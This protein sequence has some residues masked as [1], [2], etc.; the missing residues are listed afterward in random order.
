MLTDLADVLRAGGLQVSEVPGWQTRGRPGGML[1]VKTIIC[2]HTGGLNDLGT[3]IGG[4]SDL[5]GPLAQLWLD[6]AGV[7][8]VVAA[9]KCNHAG[10]SRATEYTNSYAIGIE[11]EALGTG[12]ASDWPP[13]QMDAYARGCN[14]L[15]T[16]YGVRIDHVLGHK[17]TCYPPG[18]KTDPSFDM[19]AFRSQVLAATQE[20]GLSAT[21]AQDVK[22]YVKALLL[23][24]YTLNGQA[25]PSL[26]AVLAETQRRVSVVTGQVG[27]LQGVVAAL[28]KD[29]SLTA[30]Q[31]EAAAKAGAEAGI[32]NIVDSAKVTL[33][34]KQ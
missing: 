29:S 26:L 23:D 13:V 28:S 9:G 16:H 12:V 7:F 21:D 25:R 22:D 18:R 8:H 24:G 4:R 15:M 6:R 14:V 19:V 11:A 5:P 30:E 1:G 33:D 32:K 2:H 20:A 31:I 3:I 27:A 10:V 34:V 17:E